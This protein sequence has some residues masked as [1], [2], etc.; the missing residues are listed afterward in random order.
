[1]LNTKRVVS[2]AVAAVFGLGLV[3]LASSASANDEWS[4]WTPRT[5]P[6]Q[7][8]WKAVAHGNGTFV[9]VSSSGT[10]RVI[11]SDDGI[12]WTARTAP[13]G[14]WTAVTYG[15]GKFVAVS[16]GGANSVITSEDGITWTAR[17][18]P[19]F[20]PLGAIFYGVAFTN[21]TYVAIGLNAAIS[22]PDGITWTKQTIPSGIW[23]DIAV[24]SN[25]FVAISRTGANRVVSSTDGVT[26][27]ARTVADKPWDYV[28]FS[29]SKFLAVASV[30]EDGIITST[31]GATWFTQTTTT[32]ILASDLVYT[33]NLYFA[34][35]TAGV[36]TSSDGITWTTRSPANANVASMVYAENLYVGVASSGTNRIVTTADPLAVPPPT[37]TTTTTIAATTTTTIAPPTTVAA[38]TTSTTAAPTTTTTAPKPP[39]RIPAAFG[40]NARRIAKSLGVNVPAGAKVRTTVLANSRTICRVSFVGNLLSIRKGTCNITLTVTPAKGKPTI[41]RA[42]FKVG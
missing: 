11:S 3:A 22:S 27:T 42:S 10:N 21:N 17:T 18:I 39:L 25:T 35:T 31:D 9:A 4:A 5:A 2:A 41:T 26:W 16:Q 29:G 1:M 30:A 14:D 24:G 20:A 23:R 13:S 28:T 33:N 34:F 19:S 36:L 37:T 40:P 15:G 12:T 38:T 32:G 7:N 8:D 6:E